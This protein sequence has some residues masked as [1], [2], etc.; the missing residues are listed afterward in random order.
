MENKIKKWLNE[1]LIDNKTAARMLKDIKE[2]KERL[3]KTKVNILIYT[4]A[5]VLIGLSV[6]T[7][8]S[9]N[10]WLLE[11]LNS[12]RLLKVALL[13]LVTLASFFGG[14]ALAYEKKNFPKLGSALIFLSSILI[15]G[16]Y[17]LI[18]Q[19]YNIDANSASLMF[20][21]LI[22][23]LPLAYLFKSKS[24]N[25]VSIILAILGIIYFYE[26]LALDI[27]HIWTVFIPVMCGIM[28]YSIGN[29]PPVLKK[30]NDFSL[31]Y[32][33]TGALPVFITLL[34]LTCS[35]ENS[36]H[37]ISAHYIAPIV[38]LILLNLINFSLQKNPSTLL[39][40]ETFSLITI[41]IL[42]IL[43]LVLPGVSVPFVMILANLFI[44]AMIIF[45]FN[46]GYK[47]ENIN[48]VGTANW[49]LIIY[50]TVNY[51]RWGWNYMDKSLFFLLGGICLLSLGLYLEKK[52]KTVIKNREK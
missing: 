31:S 44:I 34:V 3:R 35:V 1:G 23:I 6:I 45:G 36:Y 24:I 40:I 46:Y 7:F 13:M 39:K 16:T 20:L 52:R 21:W 48:I 18:G 42:L 49:M 47:F 10:D 2:D 27:S 50:L 8:I 12:N 22:S 26:D 14:Y 28:F 33:I 15:G 4:I 11:L 38:L 17:A 29:I 37:I 30:Y 43:M 19:I 5:V 9:A 25:I 51:C 41:L 32:K